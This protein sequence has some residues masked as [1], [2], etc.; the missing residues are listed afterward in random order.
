MADRFPE[1]WTIPYNLACYCAQ[2]GR[3]DECRKWLKKAVTIDEHTVK[4]AAIDDP[5]F[6]P[7]DSIADCL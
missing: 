3:L 7:R 5:D 4:R 2:L 6:K 1:G